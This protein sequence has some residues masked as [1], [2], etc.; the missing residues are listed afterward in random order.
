MAAEKKAAAKK[1]PEPEKA[2]EPKAPKETFDEARERKFHES[3]KAAVKAQ[4]ERDGADSK[5]GLG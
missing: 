4:R 3:R 1:A 5:L 2:P